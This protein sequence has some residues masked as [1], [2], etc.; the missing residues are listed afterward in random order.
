LER[1]FWIADHMLW[2]ISRAD[3]SLVSPTEGVFALIR[4]HERGNLESTY[5]YALLLAKG[6]TVP[7]SIPKAKTLLQ[8]AISRG[9]EGAQKALDE[10]SRTV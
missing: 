9:H 10:L 5:R 6:D 3:P 4:A 2:K 1:G 8:S 7:Q